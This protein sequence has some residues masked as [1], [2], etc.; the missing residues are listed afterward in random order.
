MASPAWLLLRPDGA[1]DVYP[2]AFH[3]R[4]D[5]TVTA[6][7]LDVDPEEPHL[8]DGRAVT[9]RDEQLVIGETCRVPL[10]D[11]RPD[12]V[13]ASGH[14]VAVADD[15]VVLIVDATACAPVAVVGAELVTAVA[16]DDS[17]LV[18]LDKSRNVRWF[19]WATAAPA[20]EARIPGRCEQLWIGAE[21]PSIACDGARRLLPS[22]AP[23]SEGPVLMAPQLVEQGV[24]GW[25][26]WDLKT[27]E[28][29]T[30]PFGAGD[31]NVELES[32]GTLAVTWTAP[33]KGAPREIHAWDVAT[34][35][36][37][38]TSSVP[39]TGNIAIHPGAV[40]V[41]VQ[42]GWE[43]HD[44]ADG[45]LVW[46]VRIAGS[47]FDTIEIDAEGR[48]FHPNDPDAPRWAGPAGE[49]A[50]AASPP[51]KAPAPIPGRA[52]A[53]R[54]AAASPL[55]REPPLLLDRVP[56]IPTTPIGTFDECGAVVETLGSGR[57]TVPVRSTAPTLVFVGD[58]DGWASPEGVDVVLY[59]PARDMI[60][61]MS[62]GEP[63]R[64]GDTRVATWGGMSG[65]E[66]PPFGMRYGEAMMVTGD[67]KILARGSA[68]T[69]VDAATR[70][71][72]QKV[73]AALP[74]RRAEVLRSVRVPGGVS[75]PLPLPDGLTAWS[76]NGGVGVYDAEGGALWTHKGTGLWLSGYGA[77]LYEKGKDAVRELDPR[78]G[79]T[80]RTIPD[81]TDLRGVSALGLLVD[82]GATQVLL[83]PAT[84]QPRRVIGTVRYHV[85]L[86]DDAIE[87][88]WPG[89][90]ETRYTCRLP[91]SGP[92][93]CGPA[94]WR[95]TKLGKLTL[96]LGRDHVLTATDPRGKLRWSMHGVF[97]LEEGT[98][99]LA[100]V[101]LGSSDG[102]YATIDTSGRLRTWLPV[103][104]SP[105]A[106]GVGVAGED[107]LVWWRP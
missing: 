29:R 55:D 81:A 25:S 34:G 84:L 87:L 22:G 11:R 12:A 8:A 103:D 14:H 79:A 6:A 31:T 72:Y 47:G 21:G 53:A 51:T 54:D 63:D 7:P 75:R 39:N 2:D 88:R 82:R 66:A 16:V 49:P 99:Q 36:A 37:R 71:A 17:R 52:T 100:F 59:H 65:D 60:G 18:V 74:T 106:V 35:Q 30:P 80:L 40:V 95:T 23:A 62:D 26:R 85:T 48:T 104:S 61:A 4:P 67:C 89:I 33:A 56:A 27:G 10:G 94:A 70:W 19:D 50:V 68:A 1:V 69:V 3:A 76:G 13:S 45:R 9:V 42:N 78:T 90:G 93:T 32:A 101:Q 28:R 57:P 105:R 73:D 98:K 92:Q 5:G 24:G 83:D 15:G 20:G 64:N 97:R 38:W 46:S 96:S 41:S 44:R 58:D 107:R 77:W 102:Q 91:A 86:T 43:V